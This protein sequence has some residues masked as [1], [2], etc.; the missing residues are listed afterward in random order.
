M[1]DAKL[2]LGCK[3]NDRLS[4]KNLYDNYSRQMYSICLRYCHDQASAADALQEGFI[5]VYKYI[6]TYNNTGNLYNWIKTI[7]VRSC[8]DQIKKENTYITVDMDQ[9]GNIDYNYELH[10]SFDDYTYNKILTVLNNIP[11]GYKIVFSMFVLDEMSHAEIA[12]MLDI[13][14]STSRTQLFKA[15][16]LIQKQLLTHSIVNPNALQG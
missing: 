10:I 16:K 4:Q 2:I 1:N 7:I 12:S 8:L 5:K 9:V 3:R 11:S 15:R 6:N 13:T 14:E